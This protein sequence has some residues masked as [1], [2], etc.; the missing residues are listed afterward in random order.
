MQ[1]QQGHSPLGARPISA[2]LPP[3]KATLHPLQWGISVLAQHA[4]ARTR[5]EN[6]WITIMMPTGCLHLLGCRT[7][8]PRRRR[9]SRQME[10]LCLPKLLRFDLHRPESRL[11]CAQL[12][13]PNAK[14]REVNVLTA[15]PDMAHP[16]K[17]YWDALP[18]L[19]ADAPARRQPAW[20]GWHQSRARQR[21]GFGQD[22]HV[23]T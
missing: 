1:Y 18:R 9:I 19:L 8:P 16:V 12:V 2:P 14:L 5:P 11:R 21:A 4:L 17:L 22:G 23:L 15:L 10:R 3:P 7:H 6:R 20:V 13:S